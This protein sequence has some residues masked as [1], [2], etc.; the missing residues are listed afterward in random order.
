[1][2]TRIMGLGVGGLAA[3]AGVASYLN[4][5]SLSNIWS[6]PRE[7]AVRERLVAQWQAMDLMERSITQNPSPAN[8][9]AGAFVGTAALNASLDVLEGSRLEYVPTDK[10]LSGTTLVLDKVDIRPELGRLEADL[11]LSAHKGNLVLRL[12]AAALVSYQGTERANENT[13]DALLRIDPVL[14]QPSVGFGAFE[15]Q[16]RDFWAQLVPDLAVAFADPRLFVVRIPLADTM[17][18]NLKLKQEATEPIGDNAKIS[19]VATL[20]ESTIVR[21]V[22]YSS[23]IV[24]P[25]GLWLF[26]MMSDSGQKVLKVS[27][28]PSRETSALRQAIEGLGRSL[29]AKAAEYSK[30]PGGAL[31]VRVN[32]EVFIA[33]GN[34]IAAL[35]DDK[36]RIDIKSTQ[37]EGRLAETKWRDNL[38]GEGGAFAELS[39]NEALKGSIQFGKPSVTWGDGRLALML[40]VTATSDSSVHVHVDPLIGGGAGTTIGIN[41]SGAADIAASAAPLLL[42][43]GDLRAALL[44][45]D[46]Q[47]KLVEAVVASDGRLKVDF[48]WTKVPS[49]GAKL[50]VPIGREAMAPTPLFDGRPQFVEIPVIGPG[51]KDSAVK[52]WRFMPAHRAIAVALVPIQAQGGAQGLEFSAELAITLLPAVENPEA[53]EKAR[54]AIA[55]EAAAY[56]ARVAEAAAALKPQKDCALKPGFAVL[57]GDIEF[58]PENEIVKFARNAW[59]D[60]TKGPGPNNELRKLVEGASEAADHAGKEAEKSAN[61]LVTKPVDA[62]TDFG[63][64]IGKGFR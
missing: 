57:L 3:V 43:K 5:S 9:S 37:S 30:L 21:R 14:V 1:M 27:D 16:L 51:E 22:S 17:R 41:G 18:V 4:W 46:L 49:I 42:N 55:A 64:Q 19:Y 63:T 36:R 52:P 54:Q 48:G 56:A 10:F 45:G 39:G 33:L 8:W 59:N 58:G 62:V 40:P 32:K 47:C 20:P 26:G 11:A 23:P 12:K 13:L 60:I 61:K 7:V 24:L 53:M 34:D 31:S 25:N 35:P 44:Q 28:P 29:S 15:F 2:L 6:A 50:Q 38:L